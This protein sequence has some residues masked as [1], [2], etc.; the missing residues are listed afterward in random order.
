MAGALA[1]ST[2]LTDV[3]SIVIPVVVPAVV[4]TATAVLYG[5]LRRK[6]P[7]AN[8]AIVFSVVFGLFNLVT[9]AWF[10]LTLWLNEAAATLPSVA[11]DGAAA[12]V[13]KH[14]RPTPTLPHLSRPL[15]T[16]ATWS[17]A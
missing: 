12:K 14:G 13:P 16:R 7:Q 11:G 15:L 17:P 2:Q 10:V 6:R 1:S 8:N 5:V 9:N 4:L 3:A